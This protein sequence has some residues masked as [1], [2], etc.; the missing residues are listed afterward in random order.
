MIITR[1]PF[2]I[3]FAGGGSD[4]QAY[5]EN[6]GGAV[7]STSIDKYIYLSSHD[8]F[9]K[10][11]SLIKYSRTELV[12]SNDEIEH[13][14]IREVFKYF[15]INHID[16]NST[17]DIP[18]GT[19]MGS[20]SSFT[21]G[22][23]NLCCEMTGKSMSKNEIAELACYF[24]INILKE[25]I[26]KQDQFAASFGGLN[27]IEFKKDL[28]VNVEKINLPI[29]LKKK[30]NDNLMLFYTGIQRSAKTVLQKQK[31]NINNK[32]KI[33]NLKEMVGLAYDLKDELKSG[34][35]DNLGNILNEGWIRKRELTNNISNNK[36]DELYNLGIKNGATGGK[37]LGAGAGGFMLFYCPEKNHQ[38]L[39]KKLSSLEEFKFKM[40]E[41]G[42]Q[43]IFK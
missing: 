26:G 41:S 39:R 12:S 6:Y 28:K 38:K 17:A 5:Y 10:S 11:K 4:L 2:R 7:L 14:I 15:D 24:E 29:M 32:K 40:E 22:L 3:S 30:L 19:G 9:D 43:I 1:T 13:P 36:I 42:T 8:F 33:N 18:S 37:L 23:I 25:P 34:N 20:S 27:F 16:F 21:V 31:D 35:L